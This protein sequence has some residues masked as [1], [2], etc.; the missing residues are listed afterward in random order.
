MSKSIRCVND[1]LKNVCTFNGRKLHLTTDRRRNCVVDT[2]EL[3]SEE[4]VREIHLTL[5]PPDKGV[6]IVLTVQRQKCYC[7]KQKKQIKL[8]AKFN[9][10]INLLINFY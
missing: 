1:T 7:S 2:D 10:I 4:L 9:L 8:T 5:L 3:T 6:R